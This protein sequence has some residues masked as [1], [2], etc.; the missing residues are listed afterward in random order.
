M[1]KVGLI[2]SV[3]SI[4]LDLH[5][6]QSLS[7]IRVIGKSSVGMIEQADDM[8]LSVP[9]C[10]RKELVE[11]SDIIV[12][13]HTTLM[14]PDL[15]VFAIKNNKHLFIND[16]PDISPEETLELFKLSEE[17]KTAVYIRNPFM[18]E[19][20]TEWLYENRR[21][22]SYI[23][24]FDTEVEFP[25]KKSFL[26]KYLFYAAILFD[27]QPQKIRVSGIHL[28]ASS[29]N[30]VNIRLDYSSNSTF[31]LELLIQ[32]HV[33][34]TFKAAIPGK[35]LY[36]DFITGNALLNNRNLSLGK[37]AKNSLVNFLK[38]VGSDSF[39]RLTNLNTYIS[40]LQTLHNL[41]GKI[42]MYTTWN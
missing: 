22:P 40:T 1:L 39:Y 41:L 42:K 30:F 36:G 24:Y 35:F 34:K 18:D 13:D 23:S 37:N 28:P 21:E 33:E 14:Y 27:T 15:L 12:V 11:A 5:K 10:N 31:N 8:F 38:S 20:I 9:E 32:P 29:F 25:E 6:V 2:G 17:A 26:L 16:F 4:A 3:S 7:G 19:P